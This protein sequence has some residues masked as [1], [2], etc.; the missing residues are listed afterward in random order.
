MKKE[1]FGSAICPICEGEF[2]FSAFL[3]TVI[4]DEKTRLIANLIT[5]YRHMHQASWNTSCHYIFAMYGQEAYEKSKIDHNNRAKRQI[6]RKCKNWLIENEIS[7]KNFF[8][9]QNNDEKTIQLI[10]KKL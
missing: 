6:I 5:H 9:L 3:D 7:A 1:R 4:P 8:E 2:V 10:N